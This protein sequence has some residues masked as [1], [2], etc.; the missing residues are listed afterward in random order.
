MGRFINLIGKVNKLEPHAGCGPLL[1]AFT[2]GSI[3][4]RQQVFEYVRAYGRAARADISNALGISAGSATTAT[5]E[6]IARG[7]L[8]EIDAITKET[9]RGRPKVALEVVPQ[10]A[11]VIGI[12]LAF[13]RHRAVL[14]DFAGN[15]VADVSRPSSDVR[16]SL[17]QLLDEISDLI[18]CVLVKSDRDPKDIRAVGIGLPGIIDYQSGSVAW[19]PLLNSENAD[20]SV[21]FA[22]GHKMPLFL[23]N[24]ANMLTLAELWFGEARGLS[25]FAVVTVES[26][27]GMG[28]VLRN[29]LYRGAHGMGLEL[30]HTK[31]QLDGALC[32]CGQRGCLEAYVADY[33]LVREAATALGQG[34]DAEGRPEDI[35]ATLFEQAKLGHQA[36]ETIFRRAGRYLALGLSNVVQLFDPALI[37]LSGERM[38]YDYLYAEEVVAAMEELTL[39]AGRKPC[40]VAI[41]A[42]DDLVWARGAAAMALSNVTASIIDEVRVT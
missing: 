7:Y 36:A 6:L 11:Y 25:D 42:W 37:I 32:Q 24:D 29:Q 20:L 35:L 33:A 18:H 13:K 19:S 8:R 3:P 38:Q 4:L 21:G 40:R 41:N 27:V 2:D 30:G 17:A 14:V 26:G 34:A 28:L 1:Q 5:A 16:R 12:K 23:D 9:G 31:V 39:S 10:A 22:L 15:V